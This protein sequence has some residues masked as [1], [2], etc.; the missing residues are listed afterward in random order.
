M[1]LESNLNP[2]DLQPPPRI[3]GSLILIHAISGLCCGTFAL[4][5]MVQ[6]DFF[7]AQFVQGYEGPEVPQAIKVVGIVSMGPLPLLVI[8]EAMAGIGLITASRQAV[9]R[10]R[11]WAI[12][13]ALLAALG[14][15]LGVLTKEANID[16]QL[17]MYEAMK[18]ALVTDIPIPND[19]NEVEQ[20]YNFGLLVG[21]LLGLAAPIGVGLWL[22]GGRGTRLQERLDMWRVATGGRP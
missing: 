14:L 18:V 7:V 3:T 11:W 21:L 10:L 22:M 2:N 12:L 9:A 16:F 19:P 1:T 20:S 6:P 8:L 13:R 4:F 17:E 5:Q 15:I